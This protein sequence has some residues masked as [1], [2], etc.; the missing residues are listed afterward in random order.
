[1]RRQY[2]IRSGLKERPLPDKSQRQ[3]VMA[4][5]PGKPAFEFLAMYAER[6]AQS[7]SAKIERSGL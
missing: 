3:R 1:M 6:T 5:H 2:S 4:N 7:E